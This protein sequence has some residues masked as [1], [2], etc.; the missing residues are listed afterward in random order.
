[1]LRFAVALLALVAVTE[2]M[3][4][5]RCQLAQTLVYN[6]GWPQ[7]DMGSWVCLCEH[8]SFLDTS[9]YTDEPRDGTGDFGLFQI[10]SYEWCSGGPN[11][12]R[13][14]CNVGCSA[15][16][17]DDIS[18]DTSCAWQIYQLYGFTY[19]D[20]YVSGCK[21]SLDPYIFGCFP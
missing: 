1:M 12:N 9:Y 3:I 17:D 6:Y 21:G 19:W 5:T 2:A 8:E 16:L 13:N 14:A 20:G 11:S 7:A 4:Y 15:L 10:N 18:D